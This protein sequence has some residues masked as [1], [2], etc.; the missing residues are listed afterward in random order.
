MNIIQFLKIYLIF[1]I[2]IPSLES[3]GIRCSTSW[4]LDKSDISLINNNVSSINYS[5]LHIFFHDELLSL[6]TSIDENNSQLNRIYLISAIGSIGYQ[7]KWPAYIKYFEE[8]R[9]KL[10]DNPTTVTMMYIDQMKNIDMNCQLSTISILPSSLSETQF[11]SENADNNDNNQVSTC[12]K[13]MENNEV[14]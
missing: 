7:L 12:S 14:S 3:A 4:P 2:I 11:I 13:L 10:I 8:N 1:Q 9:F 6:N 5:L